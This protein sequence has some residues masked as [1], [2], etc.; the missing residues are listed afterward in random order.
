MIRPIAS[1][2]LKGILQAGEPDLDVNVVNAPILAEQQDIKIAQTV[3]L[4]E[5]GYPNQIAC[6][7]YWEGSN[8]TSQGN[9]HTIAGIVLG[10]KYPRVIQFNH[11]YLE[12]N[13]EGVILLLRN[14]DVPGVI[15]QIGT[16][17]ATFNVNIAEWRL[18][19]TEPGGEALA[20]INLDTVPPPQLME[21]IAVIPAV[22]KAKIVTL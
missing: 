20:F 5:T 7:V 2:I 17:L 6:K 21:A 12:A 19:R 22:V 15:G 3:G 9:V 18:G 11:Y 1:S 10:G 16:L 8:P 14:R 13:P 4:S